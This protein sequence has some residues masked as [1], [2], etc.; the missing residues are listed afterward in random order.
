MSNLV[1]KSVPMWLFNV[2]SWLVCK[3]EACKTDDINGIMLI[4]WCNDAK[5]LMSQ[6]KSPYQMTRVHAEDMNIVFVFQGR[7]IITCWKGNI[8]ENLIKTTDNERHIA[9][10]DCFFFLLN[11]LLCLS[12]S[13]SG[14]S[15]S[16][17]KY[18][19]RHPEELGCL[20]TAI[21]PCLSAASTVLA[22]VLQPAGALHARRLVASSLRSNK[23]QRTDKHTFV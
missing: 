14:P 10:Y 20:Q 4:R 2:F 7:A 12:V 15:A 6:M 1:G 5:K 3:K 16:R 21:R 17:P 11:S 9:R 18:V 8:C 19:Q 13:L 23:L 22:V